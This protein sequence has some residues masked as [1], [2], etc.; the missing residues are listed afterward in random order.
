MKVSIS[1][2]DEDLALID[3]L[4]RRGGTTRSAIVHQAIAALRQPDLAA[5]YAAAFV[6]WI[7]EGHAAEWDATAGDGLAA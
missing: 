3:D 6:E 4:A 7:D 1:L 2:P 5:E